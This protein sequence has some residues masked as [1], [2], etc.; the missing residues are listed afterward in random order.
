MLKAFWLETCSI[1][2]PRHPPRDFPTAQTGL[3]PARP[4][5]CV[6]RHTPEKGAT[7]ANE[8]TGRAILERRE[9]LTAADMLADLQYTAD[10]LLTDCSPLR[11]R[12]LYGSRRA[13]PADW[14]STQR[15][16][17]LSRRVKA[18]HA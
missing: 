14:L 17:R 9:E 6:V 7:R 12:S 3:D 16:V 10:A 5:R 1:E 18:L 2:A 4:E 13:T 15:P 11:A 8:G